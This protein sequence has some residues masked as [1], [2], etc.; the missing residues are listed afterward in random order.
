L[1]EVQ[2]YGDLAR[3]IAEK[4]PTNFLELASYS[5]LRDIGQLAV[6][7]LSRDQS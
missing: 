2:Q 6:A 1:H 5:L 7:D 4:M 3:I